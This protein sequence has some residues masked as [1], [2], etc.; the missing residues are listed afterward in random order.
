MGLVSWLWPL[1]Y[2]FIRLEFNAAHVFSV[3]FSSHFWMT[4]GLTSLATK[5][6]SHI[7]IS[8]YLSFAVQ[9][10]V[11]FAV[12]E[13]QLNAHFHDRRSEKRRWK[14]KTVQ[15]KLINV[16]NDF[17]AR[18]SFFISLLFSVSA[19]VQQQIPRFYVFRNSFHA[20]FLCYAIQREDF[21]AKTTPNGY[22]N[23]NRTA[24]K[25]MIGD[26]F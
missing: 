6:K 11:I 15:L 23:A 18:C 17:K 1:R 20:H 8:L 14:I 4:V 25:L 21:A 3:F 5:V 22:S 7:E 12:H 26:Y 16:L 10:S 9:C 24:E 19:R 2:D 13:C